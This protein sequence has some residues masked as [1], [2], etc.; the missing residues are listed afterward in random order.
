MSPLY[1]QYMETR[2]LKNITENAFYNIIKE[3]ETKAEVI[4]LK[5]K[6]LHILKILT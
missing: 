1:L 5:T 2:N 3:Y 6:M 4:I